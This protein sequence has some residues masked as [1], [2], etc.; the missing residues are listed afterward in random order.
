MSLIFIR[1]LNT[2][3]VYQNCVEKG[4]ILVHG[5]IAA[6][7]VGSAKVTNQT[8]VYHFKIADQKVAQ[9]LV[10]TFVLSAASLLWSGST[11]MQKKKNKHLILSI[12]QTGS[13]VSMQ[14]VS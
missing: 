8:I 9:L 12:S 2:K 11:P 6:N 4:T 3:K 1:G 7:E 14:L 5:G 10:N 13:D